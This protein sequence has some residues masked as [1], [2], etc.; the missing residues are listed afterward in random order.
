MKHPAR[1]KHRRGAAQPSPP[2]VQ[3]ARK[4][5]VRVVLPGILAGGLLL[6][7]VF[8]VE[9]VQTIDLASRSYNAWLAQLI[10][11]GEL[12]GLTLE[13]LLVNAVF[14]YAFDLLLGWLTF[15]MAERMSMGAML[16]VF[17]VGAGLWLRQAAGRLRW[18]LVPL[19]VVAA[20]GVVTQVGLLNFLLAL[21][22]GGA[23]G[24]ALLAPP[25]AR[26][27]PSPP[28]GGWRGGYP[29]Q[30][31][32]KVR[33]L[34]LPAILLSVAAHPAGAAMMGAPSLYLLATR[35]LSGARQVWLFGLAVAGLLGGTAILTMAFETFR[36]PLPLASVGASTLVPYRPTYLLPAFLYL[37]VVAWM[38]AAASRARGIRTTFTS[39]QAQITFLCALACLILPSGIRF[40]IY[41]AHLTYLDQRIALVVMLA[42]LAWLGTLPWPRV[43]RLG[44]IL[45]A[46]L[47][48]GILAGDH[49]AFSRTDHMLRE[50][51]L[52]APQGSRLVLP[53]RAH[54][55]VLDPLR[56]ALDRACIGH[57]FSYLNYEPASGQFRIRA[58]PGNPFVVADGDRIGRFQNLE[59]EIREG[60]LPLYLV[61]LE[62]GRFRVRPA[63]L[64]ERIRRVPA[65]LPSHDP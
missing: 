26:P 7:P 65:P 45:V 33:W 2:Q 57:C 25:V 48:F 58:A 64:G 18:E 38:L 9:R 15:P 5:G 28:P 60:D 19:L 10:R 46:V 20:H 35:N 6:L 13:P 36:I 12:P 32:G 1:R 37:M 63:V 53:H 30:R 27:S 56:T 29:L 34:A 14:E 41:T 50:A 55:Y 44:S 40:P 52:E 62:D 59:L 17:G 22:F 4:T 49:R 16:L 61:V 3:T 39:P 43:P 23:A 31:P 8:W 54:G 42:T 51:V 24:A 21:G 47:Y 11:Q